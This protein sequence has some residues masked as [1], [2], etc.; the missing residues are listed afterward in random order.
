MEHVVP[1]RHH[2]YVFGLLIASPIDYFARK[3]E[4]TYCD[5]VIVT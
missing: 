4:V 1:P 5:H 3:G 2:G